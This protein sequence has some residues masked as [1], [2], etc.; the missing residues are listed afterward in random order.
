MAPGDDATFL[1][2]LQEAD[3]RLLEMGRWR[4]TRNRITLTVVEAANGDSVV[5]LAPNYIAIIGVNNLN[6]GGDI[7]SE[8]FE[9][10]Q[11]GMGNVSSSDGSV[12][13]IDNGYLDVTDG[14]TTERRRVYKVTGNVELGTQIVALAHYAPAALYDPDMVDDT[15]SD[16][17]NDTPDNATDVPRCQSLAALKLCMFGITFEEA[18]D[19]ARA[20]AYMSDSHTVLDR[21]DHTVKGGAR[22]KPNM[23]QNGPG[24]SPV[25]SLR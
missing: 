17:E 9:F 5:T 2:L 21:Q 10:A 12:A 4:W 24:I 11:G 20:R 3:D 19:N 18:N 13:L 25:R 23:R 6:G 15:D 16:S 7:K 14:A 22:A 1:R 8:D